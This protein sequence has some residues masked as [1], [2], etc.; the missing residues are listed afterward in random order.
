M[1]AL[2]LLF[3][4]QD[5]YIEGRG[6]FRFLVDTGA[7]STLVG[8]R[9]ADELRLVPEYRVELVSALGSDMAFGK[10]VGEI[11]VGA[12]LAK[13]M[14]VLWSDAELD[15]SVDGVLGQNFLSAHNYAIDMARHR[16]I[17][18]PPEETARLPFESRDGRIVLAVSIDGEARRL[19]LDSG[20]STLILF[21]S[22]RNSRLGGQ[23]EIRTHTGVNTVPV[24]RVRELRVGRHVLRDLAAGVTEHAADVDGLLPA[25]LFSRIY[26]DNRR[27]TLSLESW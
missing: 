7:Q 23:A 17:L 3:A 25:T 12:S 18:D 6:P 26:V 10:R 1:R 22:P 20:A 4:L 27:G 19:V 24:H 16:L 8:R 13:D 11:R 15:R 5:V 9:L 21:R 2:F 14:E